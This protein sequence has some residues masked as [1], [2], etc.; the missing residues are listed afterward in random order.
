M[1]R[2]LEGVKQEVGYS[3][4]ECH[5]FRGGVPLEAAEQ[6]YKTYDAATEWVNTLDYQLT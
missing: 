2:G 4:Y 5:F 6:A 1:V 3:I